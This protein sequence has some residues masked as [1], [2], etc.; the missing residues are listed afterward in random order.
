M[1][2][3]EKSMQKTESG[4]GLERTE[5]E[6]LTYFTLTSDAIRAQITNLGCHILSLQTKDR[7]GHW[8]DIIL[9]YHNVM[10]CFHDDS[11]MGAVVGRVANRIGKARFILNG[12]PYRLAANCGPH[13]LHGGLEGFNRKVFN[14]EILSD[15]TRFTYHSPDMEEGYPGN[16]DLEVSY[17]IQGNRF[18]IAFRTQSD[19]DTI[20]NLTNHT[21]FNL[22]GTG[23]KGFREDILDHELL[24]NADTIACVDENGLAYGDFMKVSAS[25]FDF[26][27]PHTI[28]QRIQED[29]PQLQNA[30][31]YDHSFLLLQEGKERKAPQAQLVCRKTGR[32]LSLYTSLPALQV[33]T[34]NYLE[35]GAEGK[36]GR[37]YKNRE[38]IALEAQYV[39]NSIQIEKEPR[40]I[41]KA[42]EV[43]EEEIM[44][45][46]DA[47]R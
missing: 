25:P 29:H 6:G 7:E 42:G 47:D 46:F 23:E 31:G 18:K 33:Y 45:V 1:T 19:K 8:D 17:R 36:Q 24:I 5:N 2:L 11:C 27:T 35:G 21:Y 22:S 10:D 39:S 13:H 9:S 37:P 28:G 3:Q 30:G 16:L 43:R 4:I 15:G 12:N 14:Y 38:G 40:V 26:R 34:A 20:I 41:L 44:W 32:R